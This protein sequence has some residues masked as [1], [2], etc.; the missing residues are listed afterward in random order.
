MYDEFPKTAPGKLCASTHPTG[1][2]RLQSHQVSA[3]SVTSVAQSCYSSWW[4]QVSNAL[5][6]MQACNHSHSCP[7]EQHAA[8]KHSMS[9]HAR[10]SEP[11]DRSLAAQTLTVVVPEVVHCGERLRHYGPRRAQRPIWYY[12][13][14]CETAT[15]LRSNRP[16]T[17]IHTTEERCPCSCGA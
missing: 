6:L 11:A 5:Q 2:K 17:L 3:V 8:C 1:A 12:L 9:S 14:H 13:T 16:C 10:P 4:T 7:T 15:G